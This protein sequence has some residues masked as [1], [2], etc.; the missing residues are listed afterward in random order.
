MASPDEVTV[1]S[2]QGFGRQVSQVATLLETKRQAKITAINLAIPHAVNLVEL[3]K[4]KVK[5]I[6]QVNSFERVP[7]TNKTR[8]V[9]LLSLDALDQTSKGYQAPIPES[10][11]ESKSWDELKNPP[12]RR[13]F[14]ETKREE[15]ARK[16]EQYHREEHKQS[17][18]WKDRSHEAK[19]K[20]GEEETKR[21][22]TRTRGSTERYERGSSRGFRSSR[23]RGTRGARGSRGRGGYQNERRAPPEQGKYIRER[24][25][26]ETKREDNEIFVNTMGN[27][28]FFLKQA[29][30]LLK[31]DGKR[32]VVIKASGG[33]IPKAVK[34][35]EDVKRYE[36]GLHQINNFSKR[37]VQVLYRAQE[38]GLEDKTIERELEGLEITLSK[39]EQDKTHPGYQAPLPANQVKSISIEEVEKL[40]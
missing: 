40:R 13:A 30:L 17:Q 18:P 36:L 26:E 7:N 10:Q 25:H 24:P 38:E 39:D 27:P 22:S 9:F 20:E 5:G 4:H 1:S 19:T 8:V 6:H 23:G 11:V 16:P 12:A 14:D 37:K 21:P 34:V 15:T 32:T 3:I 33:A 31:K 35:A 29:L 2:T 28:S